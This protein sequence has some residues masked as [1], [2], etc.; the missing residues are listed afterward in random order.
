[1]QSYIEYFYP[2]FKLPGFI[3]VA[4]PFLLVC[5][6]CTSHQCCS[7]STVNGFAKL[8]FYKVVE[9]CIFITNNAA[10]KNYRKSQV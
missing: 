4:V 10:C 9:P 1:M 2:L 8:W 5:D 3:L 6:V 7:L